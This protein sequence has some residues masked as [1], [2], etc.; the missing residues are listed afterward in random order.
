MSITTNSI[1]KPFTLT[2]MGVAL[3][4]SAC[5]DF[6]DQTNETAL[7]QEQ[8]I[9]DVEL[10]ET[11]VKSIYN[12]WKENYRDENCWLTLVGTDEIQAGALN[13]LKEGTAVSAAWD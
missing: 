9:N 3:S 6:L 8:V 2:L 10:V 13:A 4:L 11:S 5:T 1:I 12:N 7:T